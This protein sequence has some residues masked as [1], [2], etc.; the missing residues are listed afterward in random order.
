[1]KLTP[2]QQLFVAEYLID[3][4]G[5]R[6]ARSAGYSEKTAR[7]IATENL[8]KPYIQS[9]IAAK[10][11]HFAPAQLFAQHG[12]AVRIRPVNLE[13]F[14]CQIDAYRSNLHDGRSSLIW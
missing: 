11:R 13:H 3:G 8:S 10:L 6:A 12:F 1:M 7:Q 9:A 4:N 14:L 2:R 5:A